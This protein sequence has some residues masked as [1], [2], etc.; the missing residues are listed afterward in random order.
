MKLDKA[1]AAVMTADTK[2]WFLTNKEHGITIPL[3]AIHSKD[4][5][6]SKMLDD[7]KFAKLLK[8]LHKKLKDQKS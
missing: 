1:I 6:A 2:D 4:W 5:C 7:P 8:R 3:E